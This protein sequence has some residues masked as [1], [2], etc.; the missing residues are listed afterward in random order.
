MNKNKFRILKDFKYNFLLYDDP[1]QETGKN[2]EGWRK[3]NTRMKH[4]LFVVKNPGDVFLRRIKEECVDNVYT[5]AQE[6][7]LSVYKWRI[8]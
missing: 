2:K 8:S 4:K 1:K 5:L 6:I 3:E 7:A